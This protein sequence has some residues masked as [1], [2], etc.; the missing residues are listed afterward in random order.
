MEN[1]TDASKIH[2]PTQILSKHQQSYD[3]RNHTLHLT[4]NQMSHHAFLQFTQHGL[5]RIIHLA[6][7]FS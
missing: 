6:E 5:N 3:R 7:P 2:K 1:T 4:K